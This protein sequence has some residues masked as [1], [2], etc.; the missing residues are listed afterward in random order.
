MVANK[1][2]DG[3]GVIFKGA[4]RFIRGVDSDDEKCSVLNAV[5]LS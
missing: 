1:R 3:G 4:P 2:S 5:L